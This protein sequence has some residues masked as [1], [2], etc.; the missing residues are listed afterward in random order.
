MPAS[1]LP[2]P[3]L[4]WAGGKTQLLGELLARRPAPF[5]TYFEPFLGSGAL[6][7]ALFRAGLIRHAV[8]SDLNRELIDTYIAIRD[9]VEDVIALLRDYPYDRAFYYALRERDPWALSLPE[10]AARMIYLNKTGYNGLYRVNAQGKFN[11]PFGRY[12]SPR[13]FD[14]E[15]LRAVSCALQ[16]VT[17]R[18]THFTSVLDEA[19]E[20][21]W[22]YFDPPYLPLS[23]TA[24]FTEYYAEGFGL[25]E[26]ELLRD[27]C[28]ALSAR[29][30][31]VMLSNS[32]C[33]AA[34]KLFAAPHFYV[35]V[36]MASR[37]IN[38]KGTQR[39]KI[40]EL[41]V[42]TYPVNNTCKALFAQPAN[43]DA[44]ALCTPD[45]GEQPNTLRRLQNRSA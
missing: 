29:G 3:F 9:Y 26:H 28:S 17:L 37:A 1:T 13:Y 43:A 11:V 36:V 5:N 31:F 7:F 30:V 16:G 25:R 44:C 33:E 41:L 27:L 35:H 45:A 14:A 10:R 38:S 22:V 40:S 18:W 12:K 15:N 34:R 21:D 32:D 4:K 19:H 2:R 6:F 42:T 39:G 8:L 23:A 20:G 24:N